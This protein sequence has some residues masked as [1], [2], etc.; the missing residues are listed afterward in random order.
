MTRSDSS[1]YATVMDDS[2]LTGRPIV[3]AGAGPYGGDV[4]VAEPLVTGAKKWA[5][6]DRDICLH[7]EQFPTRRWWLAFGV[8]LSFLGLLV[9]ALITLFY[10]GIGIVGVNSP[11]GWGTFIINFVFWIGIGHAGT[12]ISAV[13][14]LF[15]QQWRTGI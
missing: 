3:L 4:E 5:D 6:V 10:A 9:F 15:R 8:A 7:A 14:Y 12:L 2:Q 11:V 1:P 13:L